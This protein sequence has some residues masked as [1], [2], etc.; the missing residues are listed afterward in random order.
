MSVT[1]LDIDMRKWETAIAF[2]I[3]Q[4]QSINWQYHSKCFYLS[5]HPT[6]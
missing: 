1:S 2:R 4:D 5:K 3:G 6:P